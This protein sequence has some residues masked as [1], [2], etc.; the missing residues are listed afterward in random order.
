MAFS[1]VFG[2]RPL[3]SNQPNLLPIA[4]LKYTRRTADVVP[5]RDTR[6]VLIQ[7]LH[8]QSLNYPC[9]GG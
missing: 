8:K 1:G 4:V 7:T 5:M 3:T 6:F 9:L 2:L